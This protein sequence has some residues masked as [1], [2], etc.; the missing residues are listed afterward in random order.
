MDMFSCFLNFLQH[1]FYVD[2]SKPQVDNCVKPFL[3]YKDENISKLCMFYFKKPLFHIF[4]L[5]PYSNHNGPLTAP[6]IIW[7]SPFSS[8]S[9]E[10]GSAKLKNLC[11]RDA[12][13]FLMTHWTF[14][15]KLFSFLSF[16]KSFFIVLSLWKSYTVLW[17][18]F[19]FPHLQWS[20]PPTVLLNPCWLFP[21]SSSLNSFHSLKWI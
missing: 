15:N 2:S 11:R 21:F 18:C 3:G 12:A 1:F 20:F 6:S 10:E 17:V 14:L 5:L 4:T 16:L 7:A 19:I 8:V 13:S 9:V